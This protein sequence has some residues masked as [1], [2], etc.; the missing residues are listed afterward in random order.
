MPNQ[1]RAPC[2]ESHIGA[3]SANAV[4]DPAHRR[5]LP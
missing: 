4:P 1:V 5:P 3:V 2:A